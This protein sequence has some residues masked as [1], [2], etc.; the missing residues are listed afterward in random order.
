MFENLDFGQNSLKFQVW[1]YFTKN[2]DFIR[3]ISI[4]VQIS[5][6]LDFGQNFRKI[7]I[8]VKIFEICRFWSKLL[9]NLNFGQNLEK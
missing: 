1:A 3:N 5:E 9:K 7:L 2:L 4:S 6:S 8:E